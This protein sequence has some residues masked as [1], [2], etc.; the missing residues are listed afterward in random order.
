MAEQGIFRPSTNLEII[1][2]SASPRRSELLASLGLD[3]S[4]QPAPCAEPEP[5]KGEEPGAY[6]VRAA[7]AKA[8]SVDESQAPAIYRARSKRRLTIG[9]DTVVSAGG[10][11]LGKPADARQALEMLRLLSGKSHRVRTGVCLILSEA[12]GEKRRHAFFEESE[13]RFHN[14]PD[15]VLA[16]YARLEEPM[17]KAGAYAVQGAGAFLV[18]SLTGSVSNVIGLPTCALAAELMRLGLIEA[19]S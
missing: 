4:I 17:D 5:Q 16:A 19:A 10:R 8:E 1:L 14:W 6:A 11:I 18:Q 15:E 9:A 13:V 2:A 3:F 12:S 7:T